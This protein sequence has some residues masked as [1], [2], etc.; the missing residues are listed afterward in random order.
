M[1]II[2]LKC[3]NSSISLDVDNPEKVKEIIVH[4]NAKLMDLVKRYPAA[5]DT[6][7][8]IIAA[9][10]MQDEIMELK[11]ELS[12]EKITKSSYSDQLKNSYNES[13][14]HIAKYI[15]ELASKIEAM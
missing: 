4:L 12:K 14:M 11:Q 8:I 5:S 9:I 1:P 2:E 3:L 7:L 15:D 10:L 13:I 6:K